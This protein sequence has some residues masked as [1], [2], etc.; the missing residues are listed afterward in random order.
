RARNGSARNCAIS[1][2]SAERL[3]PTRLRR[4]ASDKI[5]SV[6]MA[7]L[8]MGSRNRLALHVAGFVDERERLGKAG[9]GI[10]VG[11]GRSFLR[12]AFDC[13]LFRFGHRLDDRFVEFGRARPGTVALGEQIEFSTAD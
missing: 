11:G 5:C 9:K 4:G 12:R 2:A 8:Y 7:R 3:S 13:R 6:G 10:G 1:A